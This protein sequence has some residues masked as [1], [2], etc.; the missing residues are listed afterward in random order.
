MPQVHTPPTHSLNPTVDDLDNIK[1]S[2]RWAFDGLLLRWEEKISLTALKYRSDVYDHDDL[3]QV[4][5]LALYKAV[6]TY[7]AGPAS[8]ATYALT[9]ISNAMID[10][11]R[12][13][14]RSVGKTC[15]TEDEATALDDTE[16][17]EYP[18]HLVAAETSAGLQAWR[19]TLCS[20]DDRIVTLLYEQGVTMTHA[21]AQLNLSTARISQIAKCLLQSARLVA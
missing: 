18:D 11:R 2:I 9:L 4:G 19:S 1:Q 16:I 15:A 3:C 13:L 7:K 20:R 8:F 21:A 12:G 17:V 10:A 5:R 14:K 6:Q